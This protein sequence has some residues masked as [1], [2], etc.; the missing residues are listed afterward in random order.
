MAIV[1]SPVDTIRDAEVREALVQALRR[2]MWDA[3]NPDGT[4]CAWNDT[5]THAEVL[6]AFDRAIEAL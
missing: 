1:E 3:A 4:V 6:A 5:H 2:A